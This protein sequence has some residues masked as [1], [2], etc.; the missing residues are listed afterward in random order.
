MEDVKNT[1]E[2]I[3]QEQMSL[4]SIADQGQGANLE[5][6]NLQDIKAEGKA[7]PTKNKRELT[8]KQI[9]Y[10]KKSLKSKQ[11]ELPDHVTVPSSASDLVVISKT[12]DLVSYIF[13]VTDKSPKKFRFSFVS[14]LHNMGLD[15]IADL[16]RANDINLNNATSEKLQERERYQKE[17][18]LSLRLLEYLAHISC[19][20]GCILL[21]QYEQIAKQGTKCMILLSNWIE[22]DNR[23]KSRLKELSA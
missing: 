9:A 14:R 2:K 20:N 1:K 23:R 13:T 7:K 4:D 21:K 10:I 5:F 22:S 3:K 12:K 8:E 11:I 18:M 17:A 16:Y 15:I 6:E 19:E